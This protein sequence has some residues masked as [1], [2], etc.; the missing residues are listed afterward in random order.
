MKIPSETSPYRLMQEEFRNDPWK[1]LVA[2]ICLNMCSAK[3]ARP[4]WEK[5]FEIWPS[6]PWLL[7]TSR[8]SAM[9]LL[10]EILRPLGF[11][12]RRAERIVRMTEDLSY[13]YHELKRDRMQIEPLELYG[14]GKY[15]ADSYNM[16]V[17]GILVEDVKDKELRNYVSWVKDGRREQVSDRGSG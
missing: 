8:E 12:N 13:Q 5:V 16:F 14:C 6:W 9:A 3:V 10:V 4:L 2:C 11:Q 1:L 15:A 7:A 17:K